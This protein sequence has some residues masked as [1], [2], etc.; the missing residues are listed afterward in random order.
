MTA[1]R[2]WV[3]LGL[4]ALVALMLGARP[5]YL[6]L[7]GAPDWECRPA[8]VSTGAR[9]AGIHQVGYLEYALDQHNAGPPCSVG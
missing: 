1:H 3:L 9:D 5:T 8:A 2:M 4:I 6:L 7:A